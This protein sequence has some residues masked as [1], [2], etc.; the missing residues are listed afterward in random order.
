MSTMGAVMTSARA[1]RR[2]VSYW[3]ASYWAA[4]A[5]LPAGAAAVPAGAGAA[6]WPEWS[7]AA[8]E[9]CPSRVV[10]TVGGSQPRWLRRVVMLA[11]ACVDQVSPDAERNTK[12]ASRMVPVVPWSHSVRALPDAGRGFLSVARRRSLPIQRTRPPRATTQSQEA[13]SSL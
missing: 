6:V 9:G 12:P 7:P 8:A 11:P 3:A 13:A 2:T 4:S 10:D 5:A 1:I